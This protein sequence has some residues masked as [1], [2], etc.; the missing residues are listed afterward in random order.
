VVHGVVRPGDISTANSVP[1]TALS[2][3]EIELKGKGLVSDATRRPN[4]VTRLLQ[5]V[6]GF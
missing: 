4:I 1:S 2:N 3:L 5:L 6:V